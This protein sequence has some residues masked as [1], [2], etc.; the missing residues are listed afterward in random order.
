[1]K[2]GPVRVVQPIAWVKREQLHFGAF[3]QVCGFI[4]YQTA[5]VHSALDRHGASLAL[6]VPPNKP[7]QPTSGRWIRLL[8]ETVTT[9]RG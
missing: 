4:H 2:R 9:A 3:R 5:S 7:L 1:M 8:R 6:D